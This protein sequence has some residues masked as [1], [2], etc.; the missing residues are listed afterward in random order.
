MF[1]IIDRDIIVGLYAA[2][3]YNY[4]RY[5]ITHVKYYAT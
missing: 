4:M 3:N 5:I 1:Y 2:V